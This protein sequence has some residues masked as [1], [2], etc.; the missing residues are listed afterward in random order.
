VFAFKANRLRLSA[1]IL[2]AF[3]PEW[4]LSRE[5]DPATGYKELIVRRRE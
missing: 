1:E 5:H 4:H 2:I 3:L